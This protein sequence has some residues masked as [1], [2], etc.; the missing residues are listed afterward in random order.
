MYNPNLFRPKIRQ[1]LDPSKIDYFISWIIES[2]LLIS[3]PWGHTNLKLE[4]GETLSIPRQILQAQQSQIVYLYQQHCKQVGVVN[5]Q[6][7]QVLMNLLKMLRKV[8]Q[9]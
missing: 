5:K 3:I 6:L 8:G 7:F 2:N 1:R 9:H 4:T